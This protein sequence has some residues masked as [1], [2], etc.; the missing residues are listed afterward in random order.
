MLR[1]LTA[2]L[3]ATL[4]C[5]AGCGGTAQPEAANQVAPAIDVAIEGTWQGQMIVNAAAAADKLDAAKIESLKAM[6]MQMTFRDNGT[7]E[8][9]SGGQQPS[10]NRWDL[11]G[12]EGNKLTIKSIEK[13]GQ[14]KNIDLF[15]IDSNSF[16][17]PLTTEVAE[18][19]AMRFTRVR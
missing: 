11:V 9:A 19:G 8:L 5:L 1:L 14:E 2:P 16:D 6:T 18:L 13:D 3:F 17:I 10:E 7:L 4:V 15:F 12:V